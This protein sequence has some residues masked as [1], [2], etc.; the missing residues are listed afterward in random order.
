VRFQR[1]PST[2]ALFLCILFLVAGCGRAAVASVATTP[3]STLGPSGLT[4]VVQRGRVVKSL[5][6]DGR[7]APVEEVPL[8][9]K[10]LGYVKQVHVR[11]GDRVK[12][13]ALLAELETDDLLNQ[14]AQAEVALNAAQLLVSEAEK[15]LEHEIA[16]AEL[17]LE[18][19]ETQLTQAEDA[20]AYAITQAEL[21]L[22]LAQEQSSR[23]QAL[24]A[25]Y[26]AGVVRAR[27][28]LEQAQEA[29]QRAEIEYQEAV[30]RPWE[31]QDVRD[32]YAM[33][34]QLA[35]WNL[36]VAQAGYDQ[37]IADSGG[38]QH[39]LKMQETAVKLAEVEL[40][41]LKKGADPLL[42]LEVQ[43]AQKALGWLK[44]SSIDPALTNA[45]DT[46]QLA[47]EGLQDHLANAQI[48][49]PVNG[50]VLSL[51]LYPGRLVE[52]FRTAL[53][54]AD[55]SAIEVRAD[56]PSDQLQN[57]TEG[58]EVIVVRDVDPTHTWPG[59]V[60][61]LPYPYGTAGGTEDQADANQGVRIAL[62]GDT[63]DVKVG[64]LA[65]VSIILEEKEDVL[66]L[67]PAAIR[68]YQGRTFV[69]VQEGGR[70][71]RADIEIGIEGQDR[72]EILAGLEEG[73][74][75]VAP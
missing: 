50:E 63:R 39:D 22:T 17:G 11:Q 30:D 20:N 25:S 66:W 1:Y 14:I 34:L 18:I 9:F 72:V 41:Q 38:Y 16:L 65:H 70:Q 7:I 46:A 64:D 6:F 55:P 37:A 21:A 61:H 59:T 44:E 5:E 27:V 40:E 42:T 57:I 19:V 67:P 74:V 52:A 24:R 47:L 75:V 31:P 35:Q 48:V 56:V 68:T 8:Y 32:G 51:S 43:R 26:D 73:H 15:A 12:A 2:K 28:A 60:L 54:I 69:I 62:Q 45:V 29:V 49:A 71:R 4:Y 33:A 10:T 36:E 53:V 23:T 13:G 3:V 58:Q